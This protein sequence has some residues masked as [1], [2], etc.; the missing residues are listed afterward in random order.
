VNRALRG[1]AVVAALAAAACAPAGSPLPAPEPAAAPRAAPPP[2]LP[3]REIRFPAFA[4]STLPNG[5][6]LIVVENRS[7]P[8]ARVDLHVA[9]GSAADP[10][11]REGTAD[12]V[13]ALLDRGT[14]T[15]SAAEIAGQIEG[16]GGILSA[17]A[18][19]DAIVARA[20]VL[21]EHLPLAFELL[22]DVVLRPAFPVEE[23]ETARR[24]QLSALQAAM[25]RSGFI[26]GRT[27]ARL[28]HGPGHPYGTAPTP[29]TVRAVTRDDLAAFHRT[30][31][32]PGNALLVVSG[33]VDPAEA[34]ALAER[35]FGGWSG[36]APPRARPG[37]L[38]E[39]GETRIHLVHRPGAVQSTIVAGHPGLAAD[40]PDHDA[41]EVLN[42]VL[43]AGGDSRLER[44][45]R[46]Q[47]GW[48]YGARSRFS[49]PVGTGTF[50]AST[51]VRTAV[52]DSAVAELLSLLRGMR[53]A[54]PA[55]SE[56]EAALG[57]LTASFPGRL[58]TPGAV[59]SQLADALLLGLSPEHLTGYTERIRAVDAAG[60]HRAAQRW[61][62]PDRTVVVVVGDASAVLA[63]LRRIAPVSLYDLQG[64]P[65]DE[66][67]L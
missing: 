54:P 7:L 57:F 42:T 15:R 50:Q 48:T 11:G 64:N 19:A 14:A 2:P 20:S 62:H 61:L 22:G 1:L 49:R 6:R 67:S 31:F 16:V 38:P 59:A 3:P 66:G 44:V 5:L 60:V 26:A 18:G 55:A 47:H 28:V 65:L 8:L 32:V 39:P 17:G 9:S 58:E 34:R 63:G 53:E 13:A 29:E 10:A 25:G 56:M 33:D 4:G 40:H 45:L 36:A 24:R 23:L 35:H 30:H 41:V 21:S 43:G 52:T 12:L 51:E 27:F 37:A 46:A